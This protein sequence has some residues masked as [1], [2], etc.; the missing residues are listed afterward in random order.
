ML[1]YVVNISL[2]KCMFKQ[3]KSYNST[4]VFVFK[5]N[6]YTSYIYSFIFMNT[7]ISKVMSEIRTREYNQ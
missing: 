7:W 1:K 5:K 3:L 6:T 2:R 4:H